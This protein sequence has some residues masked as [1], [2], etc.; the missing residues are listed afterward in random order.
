MSLLSAEKEDKTNKTFGETSPNGKFVHTG[1]E[2]QR[3]IMKETPEH[4]L[5]EDKPYK[6]E[7]I[8]FRVFAF[9]MMHLGA[10]YA[11]YLCFFAANFLTTIHGSYT[12]LYL[13]SISVGITTSESFAYFQFH[14]ILN[15]MQPYL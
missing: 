3:N 14:D 11:I 15:I 10:L 7:I 12:Y 5:I 8:W 4:E 6:M 13:T 9:L 2:K 1:T